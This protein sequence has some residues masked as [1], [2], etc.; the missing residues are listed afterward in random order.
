[1]DAIRA[2][3]E[4]E[5]REYWNGVVGM[6]S[7]DYPLSEHV[8]RMIERGL[9]IAGSPGECIDGLRMLIAELGPIGGILVTARDWAS[10]E[11]T[12]R[13]WELLAEEVVPAFRGGLDGLRV[14]SRG[15]ASPQPAEV[16]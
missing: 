9:L 6:P 1:M 14:L 16:E 4:A 8:E 11:H 2:G 10:P 15:S 5:Q 13:S 3:A 7:P 12:R